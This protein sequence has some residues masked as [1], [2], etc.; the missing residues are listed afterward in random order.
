MVETFESL[1]GDVMEIAGSADMPFALKTAE[2]V[3]I[4]A[5]ALRLIATMPEGGS[6]FA[7]LV[8]MADAAIAGGVVCPKCDGTGKFAFTSS[9]GTDENNLCL[10]CRG[11]RLVSPAKAAWRLANP[12]RTDYRGRAPRTASARTAATPALTPELLAAL[13]EA[14]G[15]P[16]EVAAA[17]AAG[18]TPAE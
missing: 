4:K 1:S 14:L 9:Y 15:V 2:L 13:A 16:A 8:D 12:A 7:V 17:A 18:V 6:V 11:L 3:Q 5:D 10:D